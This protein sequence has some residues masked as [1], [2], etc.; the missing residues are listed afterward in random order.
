MTHMKDGDAI[1]VYNGGAGWFLFAGNRLFGSTGRIWD[2]PVPYERLRAMRSEELQAA[3]L[4][5]PIYLAGQVRQLVSG[6]GAAGTEKIG[7]RET[8][9]ISGGTPNLPLV[10]IH[11]DK[12][13]GLLARLAY[14]IE[15]PLGPIPHKV[16]YADYRDVSGVKAPFQWTASDM[17]ETW[18]YQM[19]EVQ[20][21]VTV[22]ESKFLKPR[23]SP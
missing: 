20:H 13:S 22:D 18:L 10:K 19:D 5:D 23:V 4:G 17:R 14:D 2:F 15:T 6:L 8:Y 11:L 7:G 16:D 12:Q 1:A 21:S 3:Q 9:V